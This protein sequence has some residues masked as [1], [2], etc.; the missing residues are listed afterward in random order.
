VSFDREKMR[1]DAVRLAAQGVFIGTSSWKYSGWR[2]QLY[3]DDRY[4]WRG[5]FSEARFQELCLGEY[6][7]VFK[8]VCVDAA[9]YKFPDR[10]YLAGL[11]ES[12][13]DDF[14]FGLKVTDEITIKQYSN[15]PRFGLRAGKKNENFLNPDLFASAFLGPCEPFKEKIGVL[16]LE[17]SAFHPADYKF[18]REFATD[19]DAFLGKLPK[20]WPY[21]VEI[22]NKHFLHPDYFAVLK[23]HDVAHVFNS[24][25]DMPSV[26]EQIGLA[27]SRTSPQLCPARFLLKPG[28]RYEEAVKLFSPYHN[29]KEPNPDARVAGAALIRKGVAAGPQRRTFLFVNNR[30]EGNALQTMAAMIEQA[31][32]ENPQPEA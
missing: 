19:L 1:D 9:Y 29:L 27:G 26:L 32:H 31:R 21:A 3:T 24:W 12:V 15:L 18:G 7:Q 25:A 14:L 16:L 8:T 17:F 20:G 11:M 2:G 28:R 10:H 13:P 5:R 23:R 30:L 4:V 6:A 22:R